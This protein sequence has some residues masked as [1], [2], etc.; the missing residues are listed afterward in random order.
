M[1]P[2]LVWRRLQ[3]FGTQLVRSP[4]GAEFR[5][6]VSS[7][8]VFA[9]CVVWT[10]LA[11]WEETTQPV[12]AALARRCRV[13]VDAGAYTGVYS[14]L[15]CAVNPTLR[16]VAFEPNPTVTAMLAD[17]LRANGLLD[18][19]RIVPAALGE[20]P[21]ELAFAVGSDTTAGGLRPAGAGERAFPVRVVRG[22]D[23]LAEDRVDL[24]K[25]DVEGAEL[26]A[27]RGMRG[28][29]ERHRPHLVVECLRPRT[30]Q[31]LFE[32]LGPLGYDHCRY[33]GPAG[34]VVATATTRPVPRYPNFLFSI[35][36][37]AL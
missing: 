28:V 37:D 25:L 13:F 10:D 4:A 18:R 29:L 3:P 20:R 35:A 30:L 26:A 31:D 17:N 6:V 19:V 9:R 32:F 2:A 22:D 7:R 15:A 33:L 34:P 1:L 14:L 16:V 8:D 23:E 12:L 5:Y 36:D 11:T 24:V 21:G 27:L